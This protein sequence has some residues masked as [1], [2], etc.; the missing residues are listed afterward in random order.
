MKRKF[1]RACSHTSLICLEALAVIA[2][3][4]LLAV[5]IMV[6]RLT[7]GPVDVGFARDYIQNALRDPVTGYSVKLG[8]IA[9]QW[10]DMTGPLMLHFDNIDLLRGGAPVLNVA[11]VR[12]SLSTRY[13]LL[14]DIQPVG[15]M[16]EHPSLTLIRSEDNR[17]MLGFDDRST[18]GPP[19]ENREGEPDPMMRLIDTLSRPASEIDK[20][21]PLGALKSV[22][23][24]GAGMAVA[25][26]TLGITWY[27]SPLDLTFAR[28]AQ[29]LLVSA[30]AQLPGGRDRAARIQA[31]LVYKR[32]EE[33]F[34]ANIHIQDFDPHI[35]SGKIAG[36]EWLDRHYVILNGNIELSSDRD[37]HIRKAA[38]AMSSVGGELD[39]PGLYDSPLKFEQLDLDA[40]YD[41]KTHEAEIRDMTIRAGDVAVSL[42]SLM[43]VTPDSI[44]APVKISIRDLPQ[45]RIAPLWPDSLRGEGAE[46]WLTQKLS[47]GRIH[48][49]GAS[50]DLKAEK[51]GESWAADIEN[52]VGEFAFTGMDIDYRAPLAPVTGASGTGRFEKDT[53]TV[54]IADGGVGG[55]TLKKS[56][57]VIDRIVEGGSTAKINVGL[58]GPLR[59]VMRYIAPEP[60][61]MT[62]EKLGLDVENV[63]GAADLAV[64]I[65]FPAIR[66]LRADQVKVEAKG[67]LTDVLLPD[68]V[69][70]LDLSG[71]PLNLRI[72]DGAAQIDGK[73]FLDGRAIAFDW[74]EY[75]ES[76]G[77][78]YASKVTAD[79]D[80][81]GDLRAKFGIGLENWI[82]GAFPVK[83]AYTEYG[84]G[85]AEAEVDADLGPGTLT[86]GP[87]DHTKPPGTPGKAHCKIVFAG[88]HVKEVGGLSVEAAPLSLSDARF[89]FDGDDE[90]RRGEI[91]HFKLGENNLKLD[92]EFAPDGTLKLS[93]SGPFLDARPFLGEKKDKKPYDG[94][95][96]MASITVD[97]MRTRPERTVENAKIYLDMKR[98]GD[99]D[100]FEMDATA[101]KGA[102]YLRLKPDDK[103]IMTIR[104]EAD[105]AGEALRAFNMYENVRGGKI[106]LY[107]E[108]ANPQS[109]KILKGTAEMTDFYVVKAPVLAQ[110]VNAISLL[111]IQQLLGGDGIYFSRLESQF[112]WR[113]NREGDLY[114]VHEGRTSGS[115]LGLTFEGKIDKAADLIAMEGTLV[116]VS[117]INELIGGIPLIGDILTGGGGGII[118]ATYKIEGPIK[119]PQASVNPLSVLAPGILRTILFENE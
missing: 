20:R 42:S 43:T 44:A 15:I 86:I 39:L 19:E 87:F 23:I 59:S 72:K 36:L 107:G 26:Y 31:D 45:D 112:E 109:R 1:F 90:V 22:E 2:G 102:I 69:K 7:A 92:M 82:A 118:A 110:L 21:S 46:I 47:K 85:R 24:K 16:L 115:S 98:G 117:F 89:V 80:A 105:D 25:D 50:F 66:D 6:W 54:D 78:P 74:M 49:V 91:P 51:K 75:L 3:L 37:F 101:G 29:G 81:D 58:S 38:V 57:A 73:G 12:L 64:D 77:K 103:G 10:P 108:A 60:I 96:V 33:E 56:R 11:D 65:S 94:P 48:N 104:L 63:K 88:G 97:R 40:R 55:L 32:A 35:L 52:I 5:G 61:G 41:S 95:P 83:V 9:V 62:E 13:L 113:M 84:E 53:L 30:S 119:N 8:G 76:K 27:V 79:I 28:D 99:M 14:G 17:I 106:K 93:A 4:L 18:A 34:G 68:V 100:R 114:L 71:G 116:P 67:T 111:G 70:K